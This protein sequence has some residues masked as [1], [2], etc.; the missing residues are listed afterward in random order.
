MK[1]LGKLTL[2]LALLLGLSA[3]G[4]NESADKDTWEKS[5]TEVSDTIKIGVVGEKNEV[6]DEVIK[7]Y[8]KGTGKKAELVKFSDYAQPNEALISGDIDVNS[9]QHH[10]FLNEFND[11]QADEKVV[12]IADTML[13]PLGFYSNQIKS[14]DDLKD[15][16]RIAIS[17]DP[18]NGPRA[19]FLLQSAGVIKVKGEPGESI[20][21]DD[22]TE[23]PKNL[24]FIE[25]DPAQTAR[26]LD[27]VV[28]A[29]I[30]DNFALDS[31]LS[32][33]EDA[34]YLEDP[35][36]PDAKIYVNVIATRAEDKDNEAYK[37]LVEYYQTDETKKD[38]D[39]YTDGAWIPAW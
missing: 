32:P 17:N 18:S 2:G 16:D 29:A 35:E 22:I 21:L 30:N 15:G 5:Q 10:K 6:W 28:A 33:K 37:E 23:N 31:G 8:E 27:D 7:R 3:C 11:E 20:S 13:A 4:S 9:Y 1:K 36:D 19:L 26:S 24:E 25:M 14:L 38:Y 34:I 12:S 39:K